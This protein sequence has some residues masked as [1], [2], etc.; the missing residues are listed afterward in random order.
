MEIALSTF[1][2]VARLV[3]QRSAI[4]IEPEKQY[5]IDARLGPVARAHGFASVVELVA[6]LEQTSFNSLHRQVVEA[7]T[8]N[9]T[10][11]FRDLH[12][13]EALRR[14]VVPELM[15]LRASE[16]RINIWCSACS[17]GQEPY[18]IAILLAEHFPV[19]AG[20]S[21]SILGTD[22]S[23]A[24]LARARAGRYTQ[25]EVNRGL[26][27][28][29]LIK[30]FSKTGTKWLVNDRI[31]HAVEYREMNLAESWP[32]LPA[33]DIVFMRNVLIYF[34]VSTKQ[35]ILRKIS[36]TMRP[37][38]FLFLGGAETTLG[39]FDGFERTTLDK[40]VAHRLPDA[41]ARRTHVGV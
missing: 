8:T 28:P 40:A 18:T 9:E 33:M 29:L 38:G 1:D 10:S 7:L 34:D 32:Q 20:W 37:G 35:E 26:P 30:Y 36:T 12:P 14:T 5:L 19:L 24:M 11:F 21:V 3:R 13:F 17:S 23:T 6:T 15:R 4:V 22:L 41:T 31:R 39:L 27:A 25:L 16:R 2:Y